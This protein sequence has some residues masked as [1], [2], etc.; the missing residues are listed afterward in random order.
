LSGKNSHQSSKPC[1]KPRAR[2][3]AGPPRAP[4]LSRTKSPRPRKIVK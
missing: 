1:S 2:A 4:P 3:G